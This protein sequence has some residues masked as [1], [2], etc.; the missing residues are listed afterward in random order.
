MQFQDQE[1]KLRQQSNLQWKLYQ[2]YKNAS[3]NA[4]D[5]EESDRLMEQAMK[6]K[7]WF[8]VAYNQLPKLELNHDDYY[9]FDARL[10]RYRPN[11]LFTVSRLPSQFRR[12]SVKSWRR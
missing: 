4:S 11:P 1:S 9:K 8:L 10:M 7:E 3:E 5:A 12:P 6:H 2:E